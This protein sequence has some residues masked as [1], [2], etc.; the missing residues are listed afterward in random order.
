M[1]VVAVL[2]V[3]SLGAV[4]GWCVAR[5]AL[6]F[7]ERELCSRRPSQVF[8]DRHGAV[9]RAELGDGES[10][11]IPV[12]VERV[13]PYVVHG[14]VAVEDHRYWRHDGV[15]RMAVVRA[16]LGNV[17][18]GRIVSGA[19]TVTMQLCRLAAPEPR[20]FR[21]KFRQAFRALDLETKHDKKWIMEQYLNAIPYGGNIVGIEAAARAYFAK[22]AHDL[23]L[24]E[25]ALLAGVLQRPSALRPDRYPDRARLRQQLVLQR[26]VECGYVSAA[27]AAA[28]GTCVVPVSD[29]GGN[30]EAE[31]D[32]ASYNRLGLPMTEAHFCALAA[33]EAQTP[34]VRTTLDPV[35]QALAFDTLRTRVRALDGVQDGAAVI[36][37][38]SSGAVRAL[39]GT[40]DPKASPAGEVNAA[41]ARRS[42]GSA[43]KPFIYLLALDG[44]MIV[45]DT[46]LEDAP[47]TYRHYR[48]GNFDGEYRHSIPA[49]DALARSLNT[50]AVR[51]LEMIT[52]EY[53][54]TKLGECGITTLDRGADT[55]GLSLALGG[56]EVTLLELTNAYAGLARGGRF[57]RFH[58]AESD[59]RAGGE[60]KAPFSN[61]S[62]TL[63]IDMLSTY[64]LP[65]CPDVA[66]AWKTGTSNGYRDA[67][68]I[69]FNREITIGV[70]L[71][72]KS[73]QA[74]RDLVG[75]KAAAPVVANIARALYR[76]GRPPPGPRGPGGT[77]SIDV[78]AESGLRAA[79][80]CA[81]VKSVLA[82]A[83]VPLRF[84]LGH[85]TDVE[86]T[87][88]AGFSATDSARDAAVGMAGVRRERRGILSPAPGRY[89]ADTKNV[90]LQLATVGRETGDW[91]V[92][93][94]FVARSAEPVWHNFAPGNH[95]I[96]C[97]HASESTPD[98]VEIVVR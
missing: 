75:I 89:R 25:A 5:R 79:P 71:G 29:P 81:A 67:W 56:G 42:P 60:V 86:Q 65:E 82:P 91:F 72:N 12:S 8:T 40:L 7:P 36:I 34:A 21:A 1:L 84:C 9:V 43:L 19:S 69:G 58:C 73:G 16:F 88:E 57:F 63:T 15:D 33:T 62:V 54:V 53:L 70:W 27:Q 22:S 35:W 17:R 74:A 64:P 28:A 83:N 98:S 55:Y 14:I 93:G 37:E 76:N 97:V 92:D 2:A 3:V 51:L 85:A 39:V 87:A 10:W 77:V 18:H 30:A 32:N 26:M 95:T 47:L 45:P 48:P 41:C 96:T 94:G 49:R 59:A 50:P 78:C 20:S 13:S 31:Q 66:L 38:N 11:R 23:T 44:G 46:L 6:Q 52:P 24:G 61:G 68:C 4:A 90:R 80:G